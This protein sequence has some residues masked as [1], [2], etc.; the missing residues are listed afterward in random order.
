MGALGALGEDHVC[1]M[2]TRLLPVRLCADAVWQVRH[3][4]EVTDMR[5]LFVPAEERERAKRCAR[6]VLRGV[7]TRPLLSF[8][9]S[10]AH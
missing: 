9:G 1:R 6:E 3:F 5:S 10:A 8:S 7:D 4:V 2:L